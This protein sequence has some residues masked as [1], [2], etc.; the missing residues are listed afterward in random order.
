MVGGGGGGGNILY[1][2][3]GEQRLVK[4]HFCNKC[5]HV[6]PVGVLSANWLLNLLHCVYTYT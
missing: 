2:W 1:C 3:S 4:T 6:S 5:R